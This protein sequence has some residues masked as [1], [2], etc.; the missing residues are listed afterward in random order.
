M[1]SAERANCVVMQGVEGIR[2]V[3]IREAKRTRVD[4]TGSSYSTEN[5]WMLDTEGVALLRVMAHPDVVSLFV[6]MDTL[7]LDMLCGCCTYAICP[8]EG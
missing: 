8:C 5:E 3:F 2:K 4:A 7:P 6:L 1:L